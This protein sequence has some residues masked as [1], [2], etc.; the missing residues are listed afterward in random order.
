MTVAS[1]SITNSNPDTSSEMYN[2]DLETPVP[3]NLPI[4]PDIR[5][6]Q[7]LSCLLKSLFWVCSTNQFISFVDDIS[8]ET[9]LYSSSQLL[10]KRVVHRP[11]QVS[12]AVGTNRLVLMSH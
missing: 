1:G 9:W 3:E 4:S 8:T 6:V 11:S 10:Q 12:E 2:V 5:N 7:P